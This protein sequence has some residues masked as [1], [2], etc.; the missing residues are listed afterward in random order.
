MHNSLMKAN[1]VLSDGRIVISSRGPPGQHSVYIRP[2]DPC[3]EIYRLSTFE[4]FPEHCPANPC[5]LAAGGFFHT[6]HKDRVKCFSCAQ[7]V[8][9][10]PPGDYLLSSHW[11]SMDCQ[12]IRGTDNTNVP[13]GTTFD[14]QRTQNTSIMLTTSAHG[15]A[16]FG[17]PLTSLPG[18]LTSGMS[19]SKNDVLVSTA[20]TSTNTVSASSNVATSQNTSAANASPISEQLAQLFLVPTQSIL[21]CDVK[22]LVYKHSKI[23]HMHGQLIESQ[24]HRNKCLRLDFIIQKRETRVKCWYRGWLTRWPPRSF[25]NPM[26]HS[27]PLCLHWSAIVPLYSHLL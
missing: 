23:D 15:S 13:F 16:T 20:L 27:T 11:H 22:Q 8:E 19:R 18:A 9:N 25:A 26:W 5:Q 17:E 12:F 7:T 24:L 3:Q 21:A 6:G 1:Q 2:G 10:W 4:K 14:N